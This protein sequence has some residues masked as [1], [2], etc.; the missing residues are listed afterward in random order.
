M[1]VPHSIVTV[2]LATAILPRLSARAAED[3]RPGVARTLS[4]TLRTALAVVVPFALLLP[5]IATDL[6]NVIWGH[7]AAA[8]QYDLYAP[9]L[10]LFGT[11]LVFFTVHYLML[12]GFYALERTRTVFWIQCVVAATNIVV[13]VVLVR[14]TDAARHLAR[15]G[16]R[17]QR[18]VPGGL[19]DLL[20]GP[21][22]R[23]RRPAHADAGPVPGPDADRG[24]CLDRG[25]RRHDVPPAPPGARAD[26]VR[27]GRLGV[28]D[29]AWSTSSC[30]CASPGSLRLREVTAVVDTVTRRLPLLPRP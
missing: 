29:H 9:S 8:D 25:G 11:G 20:P 17:L 24:R 16:P 19:G 6:S 7:G 21:A 5:F 10:A 2:S 26:L 18:G 13:A 14:M 27:R 30:S 1:M 15:A 4:E 23:A 22:P 12:R 3:D 28:P